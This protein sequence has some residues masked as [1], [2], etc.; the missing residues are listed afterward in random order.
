MEVTNVYLKNKMKIGV[1]GLSGIG[2]STFLNHLIDEKVASQLIGLIGP[3][4]KETK[5]SGQTKNPVRFYIERDLEQC[6]CKVSQIKDGV[7]DEQIIDISQAMDFACLLEKCTVSIRVKPSSNFDKVMDQYDLNELEFIDTQGLLDS[8]DKETQV[9][10]EI[11]ECAVLL[12]LYNI[13]NLGNRRDYIKMYQNFLNSISDKP[14]IF[15]ETDTQWQIGKRELDN[16]VDTAEEVLSEK[17]ETNYVAAEV[18]RNRYSELTGNSAY[19]NNDTFILTSILSA[20]TS[21]VNYYQVKLPTGEEHH[22]NNC[23]RICSAHTMQEVFKRLAGIKESVRH[24]FDNATGKFNH[25]ISFENCYGLLHDV[26]VKQI[27][28][29]DYNNAKVLRFARH[30]SGRFKEALKALHT[31]EIFE[32]DLTKTT[33]E[34]HT[35][36]GYHNFYETYSNQKFLD[37]MQLLLDLYKVYLSRIEIDENG[38]K[39]SKAIQVYL[40]QSVSNDYMCRDT[41]Y[42]IP[43]LNED[44]FLYCI[45]KLK[46]RIKEIPVESVV[47]TKF[48][49][50]DSDIFEKKDIMYEINKYISSAD[51]LITKLD[52]LCQSINEVMQSRAEDVLINMTK[53]FIEV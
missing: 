36:H 23:V 29:V 1:V 48:S 52:V 34:I 47:Y 53:E 3:Q 19:K 25:I 35:T 30:N 22:F 8:Q 37:C 5:L 2:K 50:Y 4:H 33:L 20:S 7:V 32:A 26:F 38:N 24:E 14:L 27:K 49:E 46:E 43:I 44:T 9:P 31:G 45:R 41:G 10:L 6:S 21:S 15:L 42:P 17:D 12:Y 18:I 40:A 39:L 11:K 13:P 51:S 28:R 16:Y